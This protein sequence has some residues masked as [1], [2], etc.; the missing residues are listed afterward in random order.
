MPPDYNSGFEM[1]AELPTKEG[2]IAELESPLGDLKPQWSTIVSPV[3][4]MPQQRNGW[5]AHSPQ[6]GAMEL[7]AYT[8]RRNYQ[9]LP[10]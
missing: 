6:G 4:T 2:S 9:E 8:T 7:P 1:K 10:G 5:Q 3:S